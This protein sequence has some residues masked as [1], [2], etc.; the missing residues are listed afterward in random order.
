MRGR[1]V[2]IC[3]CLPTYAQFHTHWPSTPV[4]PFLPCSLSEAL[5]SAPGSVGRLFAA[6]CC[7]CDAVVCEAARLLLRFWAPAAAR[8]GTGEEERYSCYTDVRP[9]G[10]YDS[11]LDT[12]AHTPPLLSDPQGA[13]PVSDFLFP[14]CPPPPPSLLCPCCSAPCTLSRPPPPRIPL[15]LVQISLHLPPPPLPIPPS[16]SPQ[17]R[18]AC[19]RHPPSTTISRLPPLPPPRAPPPPPLPR[20]APNPPTRICYSPRPQRHCSSATPGSRPGVDGRCGLWT[21]AHRV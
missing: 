15:L 9:G 8:S 3:Q 5:L 17:H 16:S 12:V 10:G 4:S 7:G 19:S 21:W 2:C 13:D 18:G 11:A 1:I 14:A 20:R 6:Y